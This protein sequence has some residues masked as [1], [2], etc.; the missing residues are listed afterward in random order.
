ML[1][2]HAMDVLDVCQGMGIGPQQQLGWQPETALQFGRRLCSGLCSSLGEAGRSF[3]QLKSELRCGI[4][5]L[6]CFAAWR[7]DES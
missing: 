7:A 6:L 3:Q 5:N 4:R 2:P 1:H